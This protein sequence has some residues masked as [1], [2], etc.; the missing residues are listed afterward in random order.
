MSSA[1]NESLFKNFKIKFARALRADR[2]DRASTGLVLLVH[3]SLDVKSVSD[4]IKLAKSKPG[5][6][7]LRQRR[8]GHGN[9]SRRRIVQFD[10]RHQD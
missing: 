3:P 8:R 1:V 10:D 7:A 5:E 2:R 6:L 4:L 9:A